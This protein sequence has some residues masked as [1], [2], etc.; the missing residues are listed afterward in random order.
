[1]VGKH[2]RGYGRVV[3]VP[4]NRGTKDLF[5]DGFT[6]NG[7][8][9]GYGHGLGNM[10]GHGVLHDL[11]DGF[12]YIIGDIVGSCDMLRLVDL[13]DFFLNCHNGSVVS[14][15][16]PQGSRHSN[17]EIRNGGFQNLGGVP[18]NIS[19]LAKMDLFGDNGFGF[20]NGGHIGV[21]CM[22]DMGGG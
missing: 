3:V 11:F 5:D 4:H 9:V 6:C 12:E 21:F 7:V 19:G 18:R 14:H 10:N 16:A 2:G 17:L 13:M 8:W 22:G 15:G 1:M 20:V